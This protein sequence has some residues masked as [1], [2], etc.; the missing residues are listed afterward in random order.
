VSTLAG[1]GAQGF[2]DGMGTAAMF[3]RP[4]GVTISTDGVLFVADEVNHR[5]RK[6]SVGELSCL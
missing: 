6:I 2:A 5:I 3:S 4:M 1:S